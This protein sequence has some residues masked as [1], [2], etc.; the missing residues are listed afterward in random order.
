MKSLDWLLKITG[1]RETLDRL[2]IP[3]LTPPELERDR[4]PETRTPLDGRWTVVGRPEGRLANK[5]ALACTRAGSGLVIPR[6][7]DFSSY[8]SG[9]DEAG[10]MPRKREI[11]VEKVDICVFDATGFSE[12]GE[13]QQVFSFFNHWVGKIASSGR[14]LILADSPDPE[15]DPALSAITGILQGFVRSFAK[16]IGPRGITAHLVLVPETEAAQAFLEPLLRFLASRRSVF[17]TGQTWEL[18]SDAPLP[19]PFKYVRSLEDKVALVTGAA[20]GMGAGI[21]GCLRREGARVVLV[22]R[23]ESRE[24]LRAVAAGMEGLPLVAD[25]TWPRA[26]AFLREEVEKEFGKLDILVHNAGIHMDRNVA[27]MTSEQWRS[28]IDVNLASAMRLTRELETLIPDH[29]RIVGIASIAGLGGV[30]GET[31]Y[32]GSKAGLAGYLTALAKKL[33]N[34]RIAVIPLAVG[35]INTAMTESLPRFHQEMGRRLTALLQGGETDDI[36]NLIVF[37]AG[38]CGIALT[39]QTIRACGGMMLGA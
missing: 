27:D 8:P 2:H 30:A 4:E 5:A 11:A 13:T 7:E 6:G 12:P 38:P 29:G 32:S 23:P 17:I 39:G 15:A 28:I 33:K 24:E 26:G 25:V 10:G 35:Y 1:A 21:A 20:R 31:A 16:E 14:V 34:R 36:G 9:L 3:P 22:D 18:S 19:G 37:L